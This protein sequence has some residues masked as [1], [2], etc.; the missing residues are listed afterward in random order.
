M[1]KS[2]DK[3]IR[4]SFCGRSQDQVEHQ[5]A[6]RGAYIC[7]DCVRLCMNIVD[8]DLPKTTAEEPPIIDKEDIPKP[9]QIKAALDA[10]GNGAVGGRWGGEEFMI[11][12]PGMGLEDAADF[13]ELLR[14]RIEKLRFE[15]CGGET[16]SSGVAQ[17]L[18]GEDADP[19]V[20]RADV[21]LYTAKKL[22]KDRVHRSDE[23][24]GQQLG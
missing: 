13:A 21:A 24:T 10:L 1:G 6:G 11:M 7:N 2:D 14:L 8:E 16:A 18:P 9:A 4:C 23:K 22:G 5:V 12:L 3:Q 17:A 19:L 15:L 20:L